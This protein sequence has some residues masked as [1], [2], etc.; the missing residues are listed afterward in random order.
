M[1]KEYPKRIERFDY[2]IPTCE[3]GCMREEHYGVIFKGECSYCMCPKY[4][5]DKAK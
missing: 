4:K 3:C 1:R 5:E 2:Y